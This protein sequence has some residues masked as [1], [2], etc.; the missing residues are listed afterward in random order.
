MSVFHGSRYVPVPA[1]LCRG[2]S[3]LQLRP[4]TKM[5]LTNASFVTVVEGD[6]LDGIAYKQYQDASLWWA[7]LDANPKYQ[8]EVEIKAGDVLTVP[9]LSEVV[10]VSGHN[11]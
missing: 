4:R 7:I 11:S 3:T 5:D 10:R 1:Y 8:H 6:T 9:P 2:T